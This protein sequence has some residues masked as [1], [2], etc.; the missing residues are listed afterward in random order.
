[1]FLKNYLK[2]TSTF[3][4]LTGILLTNLNY[5]PYNLFFHGA[6]VVGWTISGFLLKDKAIITNFGLQI[7]IFILGFTNLIFS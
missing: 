2:W 1:M 7:P 6:G 5:Y 4:V 3:L